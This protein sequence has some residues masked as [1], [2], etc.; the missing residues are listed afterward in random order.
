VYR[1]IDNPNAALFQIRTQDVVRAMQW[2][3]SDM[4]REATRRATVRG[5][6][7]YVAEAGVP[8]PSPAAV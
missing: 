7:L 8:A 5:R 1:D 3:R 2:F 4:F 6:E